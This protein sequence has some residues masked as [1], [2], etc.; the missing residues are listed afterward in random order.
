MKNAG[1]A[2]GE[3]SRSTYDG[4]GAAPPL[5]MGEFP[6]ELAG[7]PIERSRLHIPALDASH[8]CDFAVVS[9]DEYLVRLV[10]ISSGSTLYIAPRFLFN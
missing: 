9:D 6:V 8:R 3:P 2:D 4:R 10:E 1:E 5:L 7:A